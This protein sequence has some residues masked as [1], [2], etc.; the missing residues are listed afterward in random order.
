MIARTM[1]SFLAAI[2]LTM[3]AYS[4]QD[5]KAQLPTNQKPAFA[6]SEKQKAEVSRRRSHKARAHWRHRGGRHPHY[7]GRY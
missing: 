3:L 4:P 7:G 5:A 2:G 1:L 6:S